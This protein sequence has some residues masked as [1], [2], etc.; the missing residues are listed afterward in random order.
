MLICSPLIFGIALKNR[1][2][3]NENEPLLSDS[4]IAQWKVLGEDH[5]KGLLNPK[6][7]MMEHFDENG[8]FTFQ[9]PIGNSN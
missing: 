9:K 2:H 6:T 4:P 1:L 5:R 3:Q 7:E 8:G